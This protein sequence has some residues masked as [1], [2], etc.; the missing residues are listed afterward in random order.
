MGST[1]NTACEVRFA[2]K[3][4][5]GAWTTPTTIQLCQDDFTGR[6]AIHLRNDGSPAIILAETAAPSTLKIL[7]QSSALSWSS[8]PLVT[9]NGRPGIVLVQQRDGR[10]QLLLWTITFSSSAS[11][12]DYLMQLLQLDDDQVTRTVPLGTFNAQV[13]VPFSS[14]DVQPDGTAWLLRNVAGTS[15]FSPVNVTRVDGVT[16]A[17]TSQQLGTVV[18]GAYSK[19]A[20]G[21]S[22]SGE[23]SILHAETLRQMML[24]RLTPR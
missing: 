20:I 10:S 17:I 11:N 23:I 9:I 5:G 13:V 14:F 21:V 4:N 1:S 15:N 6:I 8:R 18:R 24:R 19:T 22:A 12:G 16:G 7:T 2:K 3:P